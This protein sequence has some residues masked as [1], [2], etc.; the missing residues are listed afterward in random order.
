MDYFSS[1]S[2]NLQVSHSSYLVLHSRSSLITNIFVSPLSHYHG[3][4]ISHWMLPNLIAFFT[5]NTECLF[6]P[7]WCWPQLHFSLNCFHQLW[8]LYKKHNYIVMLELNTND[9]PKEMTML[10]STSLYFWECCL[11]LGFCQ[12][13]LPQLQWYMQWFVSTYATMRLPYLP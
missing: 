3:L 9:K 2:L 1:L 4:N 12:S 10:W 6:W 5:A 7:S 13:S 8:L 11:P